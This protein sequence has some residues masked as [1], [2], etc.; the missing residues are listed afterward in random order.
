MICIFFNTIFVKLFNMKY[1]FSL[2][3]HLPAILSTQFEIL[4]YPI[5]VSSPTG[6]SNV[7]NVEVWDDC[8]NTPVVRNF[9]IGGDAV[10][11]CDNDCF[12]TCRLTR[13]DQEELI[14]QCLNKYE[15]SSNRNGQRTY[16][17]F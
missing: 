9:I 10:D 13:Q 15:I 11:Y 5:L 7:V 2:N 16:Q 17:V 6:L 12:V 3:F 1:F 14:Y 8:C 4:I